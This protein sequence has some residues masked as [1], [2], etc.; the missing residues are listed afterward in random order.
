VNI[1]SLVSLP[2]VTIEVLSNLQPQQGSQDARIA[3]LEWLTVL[4]EQL[5]N[6]PYDQPT[7]FVVCGNVLM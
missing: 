7:M 2:G 1:F 4:P 6:S 3:V 5:E